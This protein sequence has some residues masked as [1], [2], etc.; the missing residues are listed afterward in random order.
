MIFDDV[1]A[2]GKYLQHCDLEKIAILDISNVC[3]YEESLGHNWAYTLS[4]IFSARLPFDFT[5]MQFGNYAGADIGVMAFIAK[6]SRIEVSGRK[7]SE[8][9]NEDAHCLCLDFYVGKNKK[10]DILATEFIAL[11][12]NYQNYKTLSGSYGY[13]KSYNCEKYIPDFDPDRDDCTLNS[14]KVVI[15]ALNLLHCKNVN[16]VE[17]KIPPKLI[18]ARSRRNKAYFEKTYTIAI[19]PMKKA[20]NEEGKAQSVGINQAFH[21]CR[22]HFR[23]YDE[24][25]KGLFGR[26]HGTFWVPAHTR[27]DTKIGKI[28]KTYEMK[29]PS[30]KP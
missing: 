28:N 17:S 14:I 10:Y 22:G 27:G 13:S 25:S 3:R 7:L 12:D 4:D 23:T 29:V 1:L 9:F 2:S 30:A 8:I 20:L 26:Y 15:T 11:D 24:S 5:F 21:I 6:A 19:E 18:K 16:V